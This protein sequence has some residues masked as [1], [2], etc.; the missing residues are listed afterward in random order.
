MPVGA[1]VQVGRL[2]QGIKNIS[3]HQQ[4]DYTSLGNTR[5]TDHPGAGIAPLERSINNIVGQTMVL[6]GN[7]DEPHRLGHITGDDKTIHGNTAFC[8]QEGN[9]GHSAGNSNTG[10]ECNNMP[11]ASPTFKIYR[12]LH[13]YDM[14]KKKPSCAETPGRNYQKGICRAR[15]RKST[16]GISNAR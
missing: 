10:S 6:P 14:Q 11:S 16:G 13:F 7:L 2:T 1:R 12:T 3:L 8:Q 4:T 15:R 5:L 9:C